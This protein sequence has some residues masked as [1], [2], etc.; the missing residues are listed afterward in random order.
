MANSNFANPHGLSNTNNYSNAEDL[1]KLC[2]YAMR[3]QLFRKIVQTKK[4]TYF[5]VS[6]DKLETE[7]IASNQ[8]IEE[9]KENI[10]S[11][12]S[13]SLGRPLVW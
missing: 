12:I 2:S 11:N 7:T 6:N 13:S 1:A 3:N 8:T 9:D 10:G 5:Q 4:Y